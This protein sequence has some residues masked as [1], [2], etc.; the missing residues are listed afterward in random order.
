M[1][2]VNLNKATAQVN[3]GVAPMEGRVETKA[4]L[5][6]AWQAMIRFCQEMGYGE[7]AC[8]KIH[9]GLPVSAEVVIRKIRWY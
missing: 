3:S 9:D 8:I 6:P 1:P 7:I 2:G 5:H 4:G